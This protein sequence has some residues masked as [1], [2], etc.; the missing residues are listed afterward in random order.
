M[1]R[2]TEYLPEIVDKDESE[3]KH[4]IA[5]IRACVLLPEDIKNFVI[6]CIELALWLPFFLQKKSI[7]LHRLRVIIFGK[8]YNNKSNKNKNKKNNDSC[9]DNHDTTQSQAETNNTVTAP[10]PSTHLGSTGL[11]A[12]DPEPLSGDIISAEEKKKKPGHGRMPHTVYKNCIEIPLL[13]NLTVGDYCP[14]LC[15]GKLGPY[16]P[17]VIIRIRGQNFAQVYRYTVE[18]LQCNLCD[19]IVKA[20]I[21]PDIGT[22]K[23]DE[24][25][26][27]LLAIMKYYVGI[28]FHRQE[29]FQR[30]LDFPL[31]DSTQ[32][33]LIERLAG[34]CYAIYNKL[35]YY[36]ANGKVLQNDDTKTVILEIVKKIKE[37][38]AGDRTG[39]Y[40]T[41]I[42][43]LYE[44]HKIALFLNGRQHSG[45]NVGD[46]LALRDP[47]KEPI[48]QMCDALSANIPKALE[49]ILA[50]CLS[51]GFRKFEELVD[52]FPKECLNIMSKLSKVFEY[53]AETRNMSDQERLAYHQQNSQPIM[54]AL[55]MYIDDLLGYELLLIRSLP[56]NGIPEDGKIYLKKEGE[57]LKYVVKTPQAEIVEGMLDI[58]I[59]GK[60]KVKTLK[61]IKSSILEEL[62]KREH[63]HPLKE[64]YVEPNNDLYAALKYMQRHWE[65]LTRFLTVAG[66]PI[67]N[68]IVERALKI[69][70]RNRKSAMFYRTVYSAGIGGMITSIIYTCHLANQNPHHYLVALQN[71]Y[72]K[73]LADPEQ[74]MPWNYLETIAREQT[75]DANP[76]V[77]A[78]P[79]GYPVAA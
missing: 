56:K 25:F 22:E 17:G 44:E 37:G 43:A 13:L 51:H 77:H 53:D 47:E 74:W 10:L 29:N 59:N 27:A 48:I 40:T 67:D 65:K 66:A 58:S 7:T 78:P 15:G 35:K 1:K 11:V 8:G 14:E 18:K 60:L 31:S 69:A 75:G 6:K 4:I 33:D 45:E 39:M 52:Y 34:Y 79:L 42:I 3:I 38:I 62:L 54:D 46:I 72:I 9:S 20:V 76:Q 12:V 71:Y 30:M 36:A 24:A 68:N 70:I 55:K 41:G 64:N 21:P 28:P 63:I 50:N 16:K 61:N 19:Y 49:T 57:K 73:V 26:I 32:W 2:Q 5:L 23:Y